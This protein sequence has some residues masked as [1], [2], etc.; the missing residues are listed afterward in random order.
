M[1]WRTEFLGYFDT[2]GAS[3]DGAEAIDGLIELHRRIA[4]AS[5]TGTT[6]DHDLQDLKRTEELCLRWGTTYGLRRFAK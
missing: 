4:E 6:N 3:K 5:A 2:G 1:Q